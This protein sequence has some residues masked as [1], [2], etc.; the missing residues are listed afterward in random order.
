MPLSS[1]FCLVNN[2]FL[3]SLWPWLF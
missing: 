2:M 1:G 3:C